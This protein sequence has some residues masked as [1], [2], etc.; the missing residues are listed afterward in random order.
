MSQ[1]IA[2][3]F[4][5]PIDHLIKDDMR[6]KNYIRYMDDGWVLAKTKKELKDL[7]KAI[8]KMCE[9]YKL[10][11]NLKKTH[12]VPLNKG[13]TFLKKKVSIADN[14]SITINVSSNSVTRERRKLK[15]LKIKMLKGIITI[16]EIEGSYI[17]WRGFAS[18]FNSYNTIQKMN[19]LYKDL[20]GYIPVDKKTRK[21]KRKRKIER[22]INRLYEMANQMPSQ[23]EDERQRWEGLGVTI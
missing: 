23:Y 13:F 17:S 8:Q 20:F 4:A 11:L 7:L 9:K 22:R 18:Q 16:K 5:N 6:F 14:G 19:Q 1:F 12:I 3:L 2:L 21:K 15:K 10:N